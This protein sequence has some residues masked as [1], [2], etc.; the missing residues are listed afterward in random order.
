MVE[1]GTSE[2]N[3]VVQ[4]NPRYKCGQSGAF[5]KS[6]WGKR[7]CPKLKP[8]DG[9]GREKVRYVAAKAGSAEYLCF[10]GGRDKGGF[11]G[12]FGLY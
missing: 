2:I 7:E 3:A 4:G 1:P 8:G 5:R 11:A 9:Q 12:G 10:L 6:M